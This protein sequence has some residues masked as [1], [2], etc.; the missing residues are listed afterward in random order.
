MDPERTKAV[1][2]LV[3]DAGL[4]VEF[5]IVCAAYLAY[6]LVVKR[7]RFGNSE[8]VAKILM[9]YWPAWV[10]V[11]GGLCLSSIVATAFIFCD[12]TIGTRAPLSAQITFSSLGR[13]DGFNQH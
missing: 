5:L 11:M 10:F 1:T 9:L 8:T 3:I 12:L 2:S 7:R 4:G 6:H 13:V